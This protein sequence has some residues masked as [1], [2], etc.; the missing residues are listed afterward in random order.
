MDFG[1][2][3][4]KRDKSGFMEGVAALVLQ[5]AVYIYDNVTVF[6]NY[7]GVVPLSRRIFVRLVKA[8]YHGKLRANRSRGSFKFGDIRTA[9]K[10]KISD[11]AL[12]QLA[13]YGI[14]PNFQIVLHKNEYAAVDSFNGISPF[15]VQFKIR[16]FFIC[17]DKSE[18]IALHAKDSVFCEENVR[19]LARRI[20]DKRRPAVEIFTVKQFHRLRR[21]AGK[22]AKQEGEYNL[23]CFHSIKI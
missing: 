14:R 19:S 18:R 1:T 2:F 6:A 21:G 20:F 7:V 3:G 10:D 11:F 23:K 9:E 13:F 5:L 8:L 17:A 4:L 15:D 12:H 22:Q 16:I